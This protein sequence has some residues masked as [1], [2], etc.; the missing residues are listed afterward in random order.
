MRALAPDHST[1]R[2]AARS[3]SANR[4]SSTAAPANPPPSAASDSASASTSAPTPRAPPRA[5]T[6]N[7]A[8]S[9]TASNGTVDRS[10]P[11]ANRWN[12][13]SRYVPVL[14]T[15]VTWSIWKS[16]PLLS[17]YC[18]RV[19]NASQIVMQAYGHTLANAST[20]P[21]APTTNDGHNVGALPTS[22]WNPGFTSR[23]IFITFSRFPELSLIAMMFG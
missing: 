13:L 3:S 7:V 19:R 2:P 8:T 12:G 21:T 17:R 4:S 20:A 16:V 5:S 23:I 6:T 18:S 1:L 22:T 15:M 10:P 11:S 14:P 9:A